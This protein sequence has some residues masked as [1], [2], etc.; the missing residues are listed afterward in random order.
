MASSIDASTSGAGGLI[1][2]A[3]NTGILNIKTA[4]TTAVTVDASQNVGIGTTSPSVKL[5]IYTNSA[6]TSYQN[7]RNTLATSLYGVDGSGGG[8]AYLSSISG[9]NGNMYVG[10][11]A[12]AYTAFYTTATER[13]RIRSEEHTSELQSH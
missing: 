2:T 1:S 12:S 7:I 5:D 3:D 13:M 10:T 11:A 8:Y 9:G 4:G 6:S